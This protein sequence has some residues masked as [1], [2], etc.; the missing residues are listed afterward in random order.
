MARVQDRI[1]TFCDECLLSGDSMLF[2]DLRA[3]LARA[4]NIAIVGAKDKPGSPADHVGRYL[5]N[6]G[7]NVQPVHPVRRQAWGIPTVHSIAELPERNFHPDIICLFRAPQYC[8]AH[9][10]ETLALPRLPA[11]FWMQEGIRSPE[12]GRLMAEAGV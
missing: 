2:D 8:E 3:M 1:N 9:A 12:A 7:Y 11:I 10:R 4:E 6:A 5:L